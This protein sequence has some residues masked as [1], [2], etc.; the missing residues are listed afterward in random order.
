MTINQ[1][2]YLKAIFELLEKNEKV[3]NKKISLRLNIN[4][5]SVTEMLKRLIN[6]G[7][8]LYDDNLGFSLTDVGEVIAKKLIS[9]HR[10]WEVF[11]INMLNY[12]NQNV[13]HEAEELEHATSDEL[14]EMLNK[15]LNCPKKCPHGQTIYMNL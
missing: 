11:L 10:L 13:H 2:D 5:A 7:Y 9:K 8:V 1:E 15:F 4:K 6:Q 14:M 3:T 12:H